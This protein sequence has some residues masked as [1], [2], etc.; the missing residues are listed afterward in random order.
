MSKI[1]IRPKWLR[2]TE[3]I[4]ALDY[5]QQAH[6]FLLHTEKNPIFWKW[7]IISLYGALYGFAICALKGTNYHMVTFE[8]KKGLRKLITFDEALRRCQNINQMRL[9]GT[10]RALSLSDGQRESIRILEKYYRNRFIHYKPLFWYIELHDVPLITM[11]VLG[12]V[13]FLALSGGLYVNLNKNQRKKIKSLIFQS[14]HFL[15]KSKL[16]QEAT[17]ASKV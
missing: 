11:D 5:L 7:V 15:K 17:L 9:G 8:T 16:Y 13:R 4:N 12:V 14:R 2:L 6:N 10:R 1:K 3:E